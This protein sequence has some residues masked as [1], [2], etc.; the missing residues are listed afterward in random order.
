M[1]MAV[2][3]LRS[4]SRCEKLLCRAD[5]R[6]ADLR[7]HGAGV[8]GAFDHD[9]LEFRRIASQAA[10][11]G[12][13]GFLGLLGEVRQASRPWILVCVVVF[14]LASSLLHKM[15]YFIN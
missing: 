11:G 10:F 8:G 12:F 9:A 5:A 7:Q 6:V 1:K 13:V 15:A 3:S 4:T 2:L 14:M